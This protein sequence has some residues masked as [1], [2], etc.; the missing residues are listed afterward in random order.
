MLAL[1]LLAGC[2]DQRETGTLMV[3][4]AG[5]LAVPLREVEREFERAH[6]GI[7]VQ[8]ESYG[9]AEAIRQ[10]TEG[11]RKGDVL[12]SAD[13][14]LI[15]DM[16]YDEYADWLVRFATNDVV[17]A[18][19]PEKS[20]YADEIT[21]ENWY[22]ILR[23]DDVTFGFSNPNLDPCGYRSLMVCQLA[24][25]YYD[26]SEILDDLIISHT[27]ISVEEN[28]DYMIKVPEDP[29]PDTEKVTIKPKEAELTSL[30]ETGA[31][32]YYFIYRSVAV[33]SGLGFVD[34]PKEIDLSSVKYK[35]EYRRVKVETADGKV[36]M[37][38]PIVYGITVPKNAESPELGLEFV[39]F[40]IGE[41]GQSIF[42]RN[43][44][45]PITPPEG[46]G[47]IPE[48]LKPLV[49]SILMLA[50]GTPYELGLIDTL[51]EPFEKEHN[52]V[53][54]T[55]KASTGQG[56]DLGR[57]GRVDLILGHSKE[58]LDTFMEEGYGKDRRAVMHNYFIIAGP[59]NDPAC[60][61]GISDLTEAHKRIADTDSL[62][63]SRGD[64]GGVHKREKAIWG[65][66]GIDPSKE[67]W[68]LVS[69]DFMTDSL[70]MAD[71][72]R[73]YH[74]ADSST[75]T[76]M[77]GE[78]SSLDLLVVGDPNRYEATAVNPEKHSNVNYALARAFIGYITS[79]EGQRIIED[80]GKNEY[81]EPLY[82]PDAM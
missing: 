74:M 44:Q 47:A 20:R 66:L 9:S 48:E 41:E 26:D 58:A 39:Q 68:Y 29:E 8:Y 45:P 25:L 27:A 43:G 17:L 61:R 67:G 23:R 76:V 79:P 14:S 69:S 28:G 11:G 49:R 77:K 40:V 64:E 59:K 1:A 37:G 18:Y 54:E 3:F 4:H 5:S 38:M 7:D 34:L 13:Y 51:S 35:D 81:G 30:V 21:T 63:L 71:R 22:D 16:M 50:T 52:C 33:Q 65:E 15:P 12:A 78:L 80:F 60:I 31:L 62:Y 55:T 56:L 24:E 36:N 82:H 19:N 75:W 32:D 73:A 53:V 10:I 57:G 2:V 72:M 46:S 6:P 70:K 42:A